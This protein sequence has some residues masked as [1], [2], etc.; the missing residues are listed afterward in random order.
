MHADQRLCPLAVLFTL[1]IVM[2]GDRVSCLDESVFDFLDPLRDIRL[3]GGRRGKILICRLARQNRMHFAEPATNRAEDGLAIRQQVGRFLLCRFGLSK[4]V[5]DAR[6][7]VQRPRPGISLMADEA[8]TTARVEGVP[9]AAMRWTSPNN[10][11]A[12]T[13]PCSVR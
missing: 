1:P 6:Q 13:N 9:S 2:M 8:R 10:G 7:L 12:L 11:G 3:A 5:Q 4:T